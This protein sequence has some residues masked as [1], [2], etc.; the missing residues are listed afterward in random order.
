[1]WRWWERASESGVGGE[2]RR[3]EDKVERG[4]FDQNPL[5]FIYLRVKIK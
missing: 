3:D 5:Y 4:K 1:M 2:I